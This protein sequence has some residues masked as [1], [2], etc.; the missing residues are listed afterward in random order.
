MVTPTT[1][2]WR[3]LAALCLLAGAVAAPAGAAEGSEHRPDDR[4]VTIVDLGVPTEGS[5]WATHVTDSGVVF[6][7]RTF[8]V[9]PFSSARAWRWDD[10]VVTDL[11]GTG[12][13]SAVTA[14]NDR[15]D[16]AGYLITELEFSRT[17]AVLWPRD[18]TLVELGRPDLVSA[19]HDINRAGVVVGET[20]TDPADPATY[21]ALW[22]D[23]DLTMLDDGDA[24]G[25]S[26]VAINDRG[27]VAGHVVDPETFTPQAVVWHRGR[28]TAFEPPH[29]GAGSEALDINRRGQVLVRAIWTDEGGGQV[30]RWYVWHRT[31]TEELPVVLTSGHLTDRGVVLGSTQ[32]QLTP[33]DP[34][35][36]AVRIDDGV[37]TDLGTLGHGA[38]VAASNERGQ[39]VGASGLIAEGQVFPSEH[40]VLFED[41]DVVDLGTLGGPASEAADI[42]RRGQIVGR[43][44]FDEAGAVRAV[45][46][47]VDG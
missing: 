36:R 19:A 33:E 46:W 32:P 40:A 26:A 35:P 41:G 11:P 28:M 43:A 17:R 16:A 18:G 24:A 29:A 20:Q 13:G 42:N 23:G 47:T 2:R 9:G 45:M 34:L 27:Q 38:R 44:T 7:G 3:A 14:V 15:G 37:V 22:Q 12:Q 1:M 30:Q 31:G 25:S 8:P 39:V 6:G 10:G 5:S 4:D 21:A